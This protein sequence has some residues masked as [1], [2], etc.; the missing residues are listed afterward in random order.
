MLTYR[1]HRFYYSDCVSNDFDSYLA[2]EQVLDELW[3]NEPK[4]WTKK[5][6]SAHH[7]IFCSLQS[8]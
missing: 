3:K 4:E 7:S 5:V 8:R 1:F 2:A 6:S